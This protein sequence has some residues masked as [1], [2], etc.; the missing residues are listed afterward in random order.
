M[1]VRLS[2]RWIAVVVLTLVAL[3]YVQPL[4]TYVDTRRQVAVRAAEVQAL[5]QR[6]RT[7]ERRLR[8]QSS[9][10]ALLRA[11]RRL[12]YVRPGERLYV[13]KGLE[14]WR[15]AQRA[16]RDAASRRSGAG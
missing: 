16:A 3:L 5:A 10:A 12:G 13:V 11:A 4:R 14:A 15:R 6:R 8:T 2:R 1:P 7:L 9:D